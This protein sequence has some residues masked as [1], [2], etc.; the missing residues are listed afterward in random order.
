MSI[1]GTMTVA[2]FVALLGGVAAACG[3]AYRV[4]QWLNGAFHWWES[5]NARIDALAAQVDRLL[6]LSERRQT[7]VEMLVQSDISRIKGEVVKQHCRCTR[8]GCIEYRTLEYL[9]QQ[10]A[11]YEAEGGNSYVHELMDDLAALPLTEGGKR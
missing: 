4:L 1:I 7:Q 11:V 5:K 6:E 3:A 2:Q 8:Q 9:K 10:F